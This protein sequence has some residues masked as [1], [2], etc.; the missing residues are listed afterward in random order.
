MGDLRNDLLPAL[1]T[2]APELY[3]AA[4]GL[5]AEIAH[6]Y[7]GSIP[8]PYEDGSDQHDPLITMAYIRQLRDAIAKAEGAHE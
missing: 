3:A 1:N 6:E 5:V 8:E 7:G 4:K 2:V